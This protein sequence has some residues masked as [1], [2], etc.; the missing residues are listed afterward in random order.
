M[1]IKRMEYLILT[2]VS[3]C[4][5][6]FVYGTLGACNREY[7]ELPFNGYVAFLIYGFGGGLLIGGIIS[8]MILFANIIKR[9]KLFIKIL[10]CVLFPIT[11]MLIFSG[12]I[13]SFIPYGIYNFIVMNR[14]QPPEAT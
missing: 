8:G 10:A 9:Q 3:F 6:F 4:F 11:L 7:L 14:N 5:Y 2:S 12:G 1:M 13:F